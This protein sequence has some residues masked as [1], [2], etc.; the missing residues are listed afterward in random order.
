MK[1]PHPADIAALARLRQADHFKVHY[2]ASPQ[3]VIDAEFDKLWE[4]RAYKAKLI[5]ERCGGGRRP[6]IYGRGPDGQYEFVPDDFI[7]RR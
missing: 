6:V 5:A 3:E 4:A 2:R 1:K 7:P